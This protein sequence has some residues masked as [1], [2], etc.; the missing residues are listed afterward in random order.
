MNN[1]T[2]VYGETHHGKTTFLSS[3]LHYLLSMNPKLRA[4][5]CTAE[6]FESLEPW[7]KAGVLDIWQIDIRQDPFDTIALASQGYWPEDTSDPSSKLLPPTR[8]KDYELIQARFFEGMSSYCDFMMGGYAKG[9][10]AA[11]SGRSE[12]I[13]P[14]EETISFTDGASKVGGNPRTHYNIT[15]RWIQ[16]A[17]INSKKLPGTIIWTTH[18]VVAKDDRSGKAILGPELVGTAATSAAPRWFGNTIHAVRV[19][20]RVP[21]EKGKDPTLESEYRLYLKAHY[22]EEIPNIPYKAVMRVSPLVQEEADK[23]VP[24]YIP[25]NIDS[26]KNLME[27]RGQIDALSE[28]AIESL[29]G[30]THEN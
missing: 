1:V 23:L 13:G 11:R 8:Q 27:I 24:P 5:L 10:L 4:K 19:D 12:R 7:Q 30:R 6:N 21:G 25:N 26:Y 22:T 29:R 28:R 9:G 16:G 15:Q 17:V 14:A 18:E 20:R 2:C 3:V